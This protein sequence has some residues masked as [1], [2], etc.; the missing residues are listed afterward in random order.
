MT[1]AQRRHFLKVWDRYWDMLFEKTPNLTLLAIMLIFL[2]GALTMLSQGNPKISE[3]NFYLAVAMND[4]ESIAVLAF[5]IE[6]ALLIIAVHLI[7]RKL[8]RRFESLKPFHFMFM[9]LIFFSALM[10]FGNDLTI[11]MGWKEAWQLLFSGMK[12]APVVHI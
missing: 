11:I 6:S 3:G 1:K 9:A 7:T 10:D 4:Y 12:L 8:G 5:D 2:S